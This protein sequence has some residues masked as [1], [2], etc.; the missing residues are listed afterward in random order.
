LFDPLFDLLKKRITRER[1]EET[2]CARIAESFPVVYRGGYEKW[3]I[4]SLAKLLDAETALRVPVRE[5][6]P[7]DRAKSAAFA[8]MEEIPSPIESSS[9]LFSQH[10]KAIF[11]VP[12]FIV[13]SAKLNRFVAIRS[14]FKEGIYNA[15]NPSSEREWYPLNVD[16]LILLASGLTLLYVAER[17]ESISLIAD[18]GRLCRPDLLLWCVDTQAVSRKEALEK[19]ALADSRFRPARGSFIAASGS[20]PDADDSDGLQ[21]LCGQAREEASRIRI[22]P[23]GFDRL[24]LMPI[25]DALRDTGVSEMAT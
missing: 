17:P 7:A 10:L 20:W 21:D 16:L 9:F 5:L 13:R 23:V 14:E 2:A 8:P 15:L 3:A 19:M 4:L 18:V 12:D 1:F 6:Q 24:Q 25:I 11:A 22:L